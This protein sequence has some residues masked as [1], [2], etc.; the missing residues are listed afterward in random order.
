MVKAKSKS[1]FE[2]KTKPLPK[3]ADKAF[4]DVRVRDEDYD[5]TTGAFPGHMNLDLNLKGAEA[6]RVIHGPLGGTRG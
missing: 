3:K 6:R 1:S 2:K 4:N 5:Y